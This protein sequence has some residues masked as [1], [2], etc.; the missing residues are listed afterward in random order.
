MPLSKAHVARLAELARLK[1]SEDEVARFSSELSVI[2][3]YF[4]QLKAVDIAEAEPQH[5]AP[6]R[7]TPLRKDVARPSLERDKALFNAPDTDREH[8]RAPEAF[9]K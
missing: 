6:V 9:R 4:E 8:F 1:L 7:Y 3:D 5:I 2:A